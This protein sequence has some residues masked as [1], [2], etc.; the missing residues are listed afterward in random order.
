MALEWKI[1]VYFMAIRNILWLF[2]IFCDPL[3]FSSPFWYDVRKKSGNPGLHMGTCRC[4]GVV[5]AECF[6]VFPDE[7]HDPHALQEHGP[8]LVLFCPALQGF[9]STFWR[10]L[11]VMITNYGDFSRNRNIKSSS[12]S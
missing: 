4:N 8:D 11:N 1:L 5:N 12:Q 10:G 2:G 6:G 7:R 3:V 9:K